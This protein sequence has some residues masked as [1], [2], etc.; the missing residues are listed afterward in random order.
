MIFGTAGFTAMSI[1][2]QIQKTKRKKSILITGA[3]GGVVFFQP[4]FYL[5]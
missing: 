1:V 5:N 3:S 2:N 4:L